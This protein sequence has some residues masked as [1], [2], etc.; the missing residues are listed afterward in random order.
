MATRKTS[1]SKPGQR[2]RLAP[3][4]GSTRAAERVALDQAIIRTVETIAGHER[5]IGDLRRK[6]EHQIFERN[7][8]ALAKSKG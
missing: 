7:Y 6:L 3:S 1:K 4:G 2:A 5:A 8:G